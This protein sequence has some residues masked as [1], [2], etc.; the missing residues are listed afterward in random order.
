MSEIIPIRNVVYNKDT[1]IRVVNTQ[2]S[3]LNSVPPITP[4]TS[5]ESF[6]ELYDELF[7]EIPREGDVNSHRFILEREAEYLGVRIADDNEIQALLQEITDL[8]Q[9]L[10]EAETVNTQLAVQTGRIQE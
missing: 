5:L 9:Q 6:F 8:R 7:T 4:E 1:F 2:F 3:E 10:L